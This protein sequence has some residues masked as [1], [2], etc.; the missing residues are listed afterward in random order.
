ML[1][2]PTEA[3]FLAEYCKHAGRDSIN[4]W[5]FYLIYNMFRS[6][7]IIQGVYKRGLDGNASSQTALEYAD[8]ARLRSERGW[9]LAE[10]FISSKA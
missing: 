10:E 2:I 5:H 1:P 8:I 6:A 4:N 3:E 9:A 7:G